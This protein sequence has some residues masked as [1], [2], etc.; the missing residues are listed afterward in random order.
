MYTY[1]RTRT[2]RE[3]KQAPQVLQV[4]RKNKGKLERESKSKEQWREEKGKRD[5]RRE[6]YQHKENVKTKKK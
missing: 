1:K 2:S 4:R 5:R 6:T 3:S